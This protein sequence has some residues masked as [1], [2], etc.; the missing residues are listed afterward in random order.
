MRSGV[1]VFPGSNCE[2]DVYHVLKHVLGQ[3]TRYLWHKD[4]EI[5]DCDL[6]VVPGGF[7]YGDY[8]RSGAVAAHS[9]ILA[10]VR[11]HAEAGGLVLGICNGFQIL[12]QANL[13]PG[14]LIH[15]RDLRFLC[16][17]AWL[18][19]ERADLPFTRGYHQGQVIRIPMAHG[20]GNFQASEEQLDRLEA[21]GQ[22]V[23]R[24]RIDNANGSA[25]AIAGIVNE[26]GNVL[27][28]MPHPERAAE[29]VLGN[30]DGLAFFAGLVESVA[31]SATSG[32]PLEVA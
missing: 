5:Q 9:P 29:S 13:L 28:L 15:N 18:Q 3:S 14:A 12:Q 22:V 17:D 2:H 20:E 1:I 19:V 10:A 6:V 24:Y 11:R 7:S 25:R 32:S 31:A 23:F 30:D 16:V 4:Q 27:G 21:N 26:R 8:L